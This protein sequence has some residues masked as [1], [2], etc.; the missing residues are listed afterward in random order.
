MSPG[1]KIAVTK[2][3]LVLKTNTYHPIIPLQM[4]LTWSNLVIAIAISFLWSVRRF[5]SSV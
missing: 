1:L 4:A 5:E 3:V 2:M